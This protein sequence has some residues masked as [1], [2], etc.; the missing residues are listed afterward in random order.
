VK[1]CLFGAFLLVVLVACAQVGTAEPTLKNCINRCWLTKE[2]YSCTGKSY[3][4]YSEKTC[5]YCN[6]SKKDN[7]ISEYK[8][9][10]GH[11]CLVTDTKCSIWFGTSGD[12][13]DCLPGGAGAQASDIGGLGSEIPNIAIWDC[14]EEA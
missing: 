4:K 3:V 10:P 8:E 14:I 6:E 2:F 9:Q 7:C 1:R 11:M 13:C 12:K 5:T